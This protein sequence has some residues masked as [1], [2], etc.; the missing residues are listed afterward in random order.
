[1]AASAPARSMDALW[2]LV[3][4]QTTLALAVAALVVLGWDELPF[5]EAGSWAL[6]VI[7]TAHAA[8][9]FWSWWRAT[10]RLADGYTVFLL[11]LVLFSGGELVLQAF[12]VPLQGGF[13]TLTAW[14]TIVLVTSSV[15]GFHL[16]ALGL[17]ALRGA[18]AAQ[19]GNPLPAV[20]SRASFR[21]IGWVFLAAALPVTIVRTVKSIQV[22]AAS[23]YFGL[24]Q[25]DVRTGIGNWDAVL[26]G[27]LVPA[28]LI[29]LATRPERRAN[30]WL[31]W[32]VGA[33]GVAANLFFGARAAAIT[34]L[35]PMLLLHD[36]AV[37]R[38][39]GLVV[40]AVFVTGFLAMPI[41]AE[42]RDLNLSERAAATERTTFDAQ[43]L[44][45]SALGEMGGTMW[46]VAH[47]I[48]RVPSHRPFEDGLGYGRAALAILPNLFWDVHPAVANG[49]YAQWLIRSVDPFVAEAGGGLGF[50]MIAE[51]Y[52]NGHKGGAVLVMFAAGF[53][54][55]SFVAWA[56]SRGHVFHL[57]IEAIVISV[58]LALPRSES[59][60]V[61]RQIVWCAV[62]PYLVVR[63]ARSSR[64]HE[65]DALYA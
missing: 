59:L 10:G 11:S 48:E 6:C 57:C 17:L 65:P 18:A 14:R 43:R 55:A 50:S 8:W 52:I 16:G 44:A 21:R 61:V 7:Y 41:I 53:L 63:F 64:L 46:T 60:A 38:I 58:L 4:I 15:V 26:A 1:M 3:V 39:R 23:G 35:L 32:V 2:A 40:A 42:L 33:A 31:C 5:G 36:R 24:Y 45:R 22:V 27:F 12:G 49:S 29:L 51:A 13:G 62:V 37:G 28:L 20:Y 25:Q 56:R 19:H 9:A 47:T 54:L 34:M 30:V